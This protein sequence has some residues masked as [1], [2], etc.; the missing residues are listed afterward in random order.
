MEHEQ[1][2][3][4]EEST[5]ENSEPEEIDEF[6]DDEMSRDVVVPGEV[7]TDDTTNFLTGRGTIFNSDRSKI[8]SLNIGLKIQLN[9]LP[10]FYIQMFCFLNKIPES[11]HHT[12]K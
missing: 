3:S 12:Y 2:K 6:D 11:P 9:V 1:D 4:I 8:I 5:T 7:L 10:R